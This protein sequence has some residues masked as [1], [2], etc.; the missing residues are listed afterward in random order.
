IRATPAGHFR[1][2]RRKGGPAS[3]GKRYRGGVAPPAGKMA[4]RLRTSTRTTKRKHCRLHRGKRVARGHGGL[5]HV[6]GGARRGPG[7]HHAHARAGGGA[8]SETEPFPRRG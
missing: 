7:A 6:S 2:R 5:L 1:S 8:I 3:P 4:S